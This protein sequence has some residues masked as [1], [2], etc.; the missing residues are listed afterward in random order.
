[1]TV[2]V[3]DWDSHCRSWSTE[4][5]G[6]GSFAI[7][8]RPRT[9]N[10]GTLSPGVNEEF[11]DRSYS[12]FRIRLGDRSAH[13]LA[14]GERCPGHRRVH[15]FHGWVPFAAGFYLVMPVGAARSSRLT[16]ITMIVMI[17]ASS[18]TRAEISKARE[19]PAASA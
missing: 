5:E 15:G 3:M 17:S 8:Q 16:R 18:A 13:Q 14:S 7:R 4:P 2:A 1:M 19:N 9:G 10:S 12:A 11:M 6:W